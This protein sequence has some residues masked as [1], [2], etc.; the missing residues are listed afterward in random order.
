MPYIYPETAE[1]VHNGDVVGVARRVRRAVGVREAPATTAMVVIS[2]HAYLV[3]DCG[4]Q[5]QPCQ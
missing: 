2:V 1:C 3:V 4:R 5:L